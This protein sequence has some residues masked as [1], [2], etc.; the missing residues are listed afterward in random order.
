[1]SGPSRPIDSYS[2]RRRAASS[3]ITRR[4]YPRRVDRDPSA[5]RGELIR[6]GLARRCPRCGAPAFDSWFTLR[7]T[8]PDCGLEFER[9]PGYW[10]GAVIIN[11]TVIF[12]TFLLVFGGMVL[13]TYPDVPW[14]WVLAVT[15]LANV[16]I[17]IVFYPISKSLW[18][19]MELS[20]HQLEPEEIEAA[21]RR[22]S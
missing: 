3:R 11:T 4:R 2:L 21:T 17:P 7:E 8:C 16:I 15:A 6:R 22:V 1:M 18:S 10:V 14:G 5:S 19:G 12:A 9:E 20:W 13:L